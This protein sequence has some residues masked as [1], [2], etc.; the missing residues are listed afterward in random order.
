MYIN[1]D[2]VL[3]LRDM[4]AIELRCVE[5]TLISQFLEKGLAPDYRWL[6]MFP[7]S[8][9]AASHHIRNPPPL[10][11]DR[12]LILPPLDRTEQALCRVGERIAAIKSLRN[13]IPNPDKLPLLKACK[14]HVDDWCAE[15]KAS[16]VKFLEFTP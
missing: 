6:K 11:E 7:N 5:D 12:T 14:D 16:G 13:R 1:I 2:F 3:L 8:L 4:G 9:I 15:A 10:V